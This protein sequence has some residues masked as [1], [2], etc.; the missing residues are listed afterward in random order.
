MVSIFVAVSLLCLS[1]SAAALAA[2]DEA[3]QRP[4]SPERQWPVVKE[5]FASLL[6]ADARLGGPARQPVDAVAE[7]LAEQY[8]RELAQTSSG[9]FSSK[10]I[11]ASFERLFM[12]NFYRPCSTL[13]ELAASPPTSA[14]MQRVR[15]ELNPV[16]FENLLQLC[17]KVLEPLS[18]Y[19]AYARFKSLARSR[20]GQSE[21]E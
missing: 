12:G 16:R 6:R 17:R 11:E 13:S 15:R 14:N 18:R 8:A 2:D 19:D 20:P 10:R 21:R 3:A 7:V 9:W 5:Y 1:S 4:A